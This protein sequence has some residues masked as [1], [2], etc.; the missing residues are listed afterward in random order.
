MYVW[1][2]Q[3]QDIWLTAAAL[4]AN[5]T[6]VSH[7]DQLKVRGWKRKGK[8]ICLPLLGMLNN[9]HQSQILS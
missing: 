4:L 8:R 1:F 5:A 6:N 7:R 2:M 9:V 3:Q